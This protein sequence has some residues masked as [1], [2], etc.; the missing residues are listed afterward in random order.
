M[1]Q[2]LLYPGH[3]HRSRNASLPRPPCALRNCYGV[4]MEV[5]FYLPLVLWKCLWHGFK[6]VVML[7]ALNTSKPSALARAQWLKNNRLQVIEGCQPSS[8]RGNLMSSRVTRR[9]T[10]RPQRGRY[11]VDREGTQ[12]ALETTL[13][14][15]GIVL[16]LVEPSNDPNMSSKRRKTSLD[17][18]VT[19]STTRTQT[20]EEMRS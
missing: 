2:T 18:E 10:L 6:L 14:K 3:S 12:Q 8:A 5:V 13:K 17:S 15:L 16:Q 7:D 19:A 20:D 1:P 11:Y 9:S 4:M